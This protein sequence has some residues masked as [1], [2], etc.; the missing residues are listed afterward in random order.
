ML[1]SYSTPLSFLY[2]A[3][4][5]LQPSIKIRLSRSFLWKYVAFM[6]SRIQLIVVYLNTLVMAWIW[7]AARRFELQTVFKESSE[8][9][10]YGSVSHV[11]MSRR[12]RAKLWH[13]LSFA[14]LHHPW[15]G[16]NWLALLSAEPIPQK[17]ALLCRSLEYYRPWICGPYQNCSLQLTI[18]IPTFVK[19]QRRK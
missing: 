6:Q 3:L 12:A 5:D 9:V 8:I 10:V 1:A 15:V 17:T 4:Q 16:L 18:Q 19:R 7:V 11:E 14:P 2:P 13:T